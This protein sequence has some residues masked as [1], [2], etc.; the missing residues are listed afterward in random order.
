MCTGGR[1]IGG[2]GV[3][4]S[5]LLSDPTI[6]GGGGVLGAFGFSMSLVPLAAHD[7]MLS[8][9]VR[10]VRFS[11]TGGATT[12]GTA[13]AGIVVANGCAVSA[14]RALE[15]VLNEG[16]GGGGGREFIG[17]VIRRGAKKLPDY[18]RGHF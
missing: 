14:A 17:Q 11:I 5:V 16:G 4:G 3:D 1:H 6:A 18:F 12:V 9:S 2:G 13:E 15:G 8:S 10:S 7:S